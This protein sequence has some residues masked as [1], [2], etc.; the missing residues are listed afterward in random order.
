MEQNAAQS[1]RVMKFGG[2]SV[3]D[4]ARWSTIAKLAQDR[5]KSGERV[6]IVHSA[7]SGVSNALEALPE[8]CLEG[9]GELEAQAIKDR[10]LA[11]A[12]EAGLEGEALLSDLFDTLDRLTAGIALIGEA[13]AARARRNVVAGRV[14]GQ[15][16]G[17]WPVWKLKACRR[18]CWT[19]ATRWPRP[20]RAKTGALI[21][22]TR[23]G[24]DQPTRRWP[25][26]CP[27]PSS[28]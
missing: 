26:A 16:A 18:L 13:S 23:C 25:S 14:D 27:A 17:R 8:A 28:R 22:T 7:L 24:D 3:A 11:F 2:V 15:P 1:W 4:P 12:A 20:I 9:R 10:H 21:W 19:R 6:L 5:L